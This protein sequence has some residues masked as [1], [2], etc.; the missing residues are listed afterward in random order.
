MTA[1]KFTTMQERLD[2]MERTNPAVRRAREKYDR[3]VASILADAR[4]RSPEC[5]P[6]PASDEHARYVEYGRGLGYVHGPRVKR[7][8]PCGLYVWPDDDSRS[9]PREA[10]PGEVVTCPRCVAAMGSGG[11][12]R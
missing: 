9:C 12:T 2:E 1:R 3:V 11:R 4:A 7:A 6:F 8:H 10:K 5:A